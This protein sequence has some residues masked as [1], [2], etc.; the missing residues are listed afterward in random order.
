LKE[1]LSTVQ[2]ILAEQKQIM[3]RQQEEVEALRHQVNLKERQ[4]VQLLDF[5]SKGRNEEEMPEIDTRESEA[6]HS[7]FYKRVYLAE[8][9]QTL[10]SRQSNFKSVGS[11]VR[12]SPLKGG[13]EVVPEFSYKLY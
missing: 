4:R 2:S 6:E 9:N 7:G 5:L 8:L 10:T 3:K 11:S 13:K 12:G 1:E